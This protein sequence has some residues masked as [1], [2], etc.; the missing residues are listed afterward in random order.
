MMY[1]Y[2]LFGLLL[3]SLLACN[4]N[5]VPAAGTASDAATSVS[6]TAN[7]IDNAVGSSDKHQPDTAIRTLFE[8]VS[9]L[10]GHTAARPKQFGWHTAEGYTELNGWA[11]QHHFPKQAIS[12]TMAQI[13]PIEAVLHGSWETDIHNAAD[14]VYSSITGWRQNQTVCLLYGEPNDHGTDVDQ[15]DMA[16]EDP[17]LSYRIE[18]SCAAFNQ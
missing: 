1:Q 16:E 15:N 8:Q 5:P 4:A 12:K 2:S 14:G 11:L 13:E 10:M 3:C 17:A 18:L 7:H 6:D 9:P